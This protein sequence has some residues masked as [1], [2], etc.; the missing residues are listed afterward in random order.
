[1]QRAFRQHMSACNEGKTHK[2]TANA[3]IVAATI[4]SKWHCE[5]FVLL[6]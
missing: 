2:E 5:E 6:Q 1:M 3:V 4:A